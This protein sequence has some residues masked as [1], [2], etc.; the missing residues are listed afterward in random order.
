VVRDHDRI[1]GMIEWIDLR[2][3]WREVSMNEKYLC[4]I[5]IVALLCIT[6]LVGYALSLGIDGA[7]LGTALSIFGL[8]VGAVAKTIY[9]KGKT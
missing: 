8:V 5:V 9:D 3:N 2:N 1:R 4:V 7:V 6:G